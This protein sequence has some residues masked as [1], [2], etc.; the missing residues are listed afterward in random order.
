MVYRGGSL[1]I[2]ICGHTGIVRKKGTLDTSQFLE[3]SKVAMKNGSVGIMIL[4]MGG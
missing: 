3:R 4:Y 2:T 1:Q